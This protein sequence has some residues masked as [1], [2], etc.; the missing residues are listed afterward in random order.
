MAVRIVTA[1]MVLFLARFLEVAPGTAR[2]G[3]LHRSAQ[4]HDANQGGDQHRLADEVPQR[5]ADELVG[6]GGRRSD[7]PPDEHGQEP[8]QDDADPPPLQ[9][10]RPQ[11]GP[12]HGKGP[13]GDPSDEGEQRQQHPPDTDGQYRQIVKEVEQ[14]VKYCVHRQLIAIS[15]E[16]AH[17]VCTSGLPES[18]A[19]CHCLGRTEPWQNTGLA[20]RRV[21]DQNEPRDGRGRRQKTGQSLPPSGV[22]T[23]CVRLLKMRPVP[24]LPVCPTPL[25]DRRAS[26]CRC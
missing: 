22:A 2:A 10:D 8:E 24:A 15:G 18:P 16:S 13:K 19:G 3:K 25:R 7:R 11:L 6:A 1:V 12:V 4:Q 14:V 5:Q 17:F 26:N 9:Q 23:S 21:F 20:A